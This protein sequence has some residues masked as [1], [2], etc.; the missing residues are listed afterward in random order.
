M[1]LLALLNNYLERESEKCSH[2][3]VHHIQMFFV[4]ISRK[5]WSLMFINGG[6]LLFLFRSVN[7]YTTMSYFWTKKKNKL[8]T[9]KSMFLTDIWFN[10]LKTFS[11]VWLIACVKKGVI[12]H[13]ILQSVAFYHIY[14]W[15]TIVFIQQIV[16][17]YVCSKACSYKTKPN[18]S[19]KLKLN[20]FWV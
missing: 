7:Q 8:S 13:M 16:T 4:R 9:I 3:Y 20:F 18:V 6:K 14:Y 10:W 12:T 2:L 11:N 5:R 1:S 17:M 15:S 19:L